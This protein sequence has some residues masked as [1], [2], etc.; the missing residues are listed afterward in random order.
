MSSLE[1]IVKAAFFTL[2]PEG[3]WGLPLLLWGEPG[4][5]KTHLIKAI[6]RRWG[7][8]VERLSPGERGEGQFGVVPVPG[9]DGFLHYPAP[10][11]AG[12][13]SEGGVIFVDEL[14]TSSPALQASLLGLI[15]LRTIGSHTFG[16]HV[17]TIGAAN[18]TSDGA[19]AWDLAPAINNRFGHLKVEGLEAHDWITGYLGGWGAAE[20]D[21]QDATAEENRVLAAWASA[22]AVAKGQ[23]AGFISRRPDLLHKRPAEGAPDSRAWP[24]RRSVDYAGAVLASSKIHNLTETETYDFLGGFVG[25]AWVGEFHRWRVDADLPDPADVLDGRVKFE[26]SAA[27]PDRT[28]AVLASCAALVAPKTAQNR[29]AR[30]DVAWQIVAQVADTAIDLAAPAARALCAALLFTPASTKVLVR[31]QG[32]FKAAGV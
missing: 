25:Q 24:S 15:Q 29:Q 5:G 4:T 11:W 27:R 1:N 23:I 20:D 7:L 17:R 22:E 16:A 13:F 28:I 9:A 10:A 8:A 21:V 30:A 26:H 6:C 18:E 3:F 12:K 14:N 31:F 32:L 2:S 19:G